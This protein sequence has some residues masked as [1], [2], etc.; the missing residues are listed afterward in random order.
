MKHVSLRLR[1]QDMTAYD[2]LEHEKTIDR[3][4]RYGG[5]DDCERAEILHLYMTY[6]IMKQC[7]AD[8][9]RI[10]RNDDYL[11]GNDYL[12]IL[13][14]E[15]HTAIDT[16]KRVLQSNDLI[17]KASAVAGLRMIMPSSKPT[18]LFDVF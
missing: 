3:I 15:L 2:R 6:K 17:H 11:A 8:A 13:V 12:D 5:L 9:R 16:Y 1:T 14:D 4:M 18:T 10:M 7:K